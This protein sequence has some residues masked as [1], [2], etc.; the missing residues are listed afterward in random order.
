M[1]AAPPVPASQEANYDHISGD[2]PYLKRSYG[3]L[4]IKDMTQLYDDWAQTYD[5]DVI[6]GEEYKAPPLVAETILQNLGSSTI[7]PSVQILDVGCGTGLVGISLAKLGAQQVDGI[8]LSPGMLAIARKAGVY[9]KL[10][11]ADITK[12]IAFADE[13]YDVVSCVGTFT[14]GHVGPSALNEL[15]R[16]A[17]RKGLIVATVLDEIYEKLGYKA[18]VEKL[19]ADGKVEVI[20]TETMLYRTK[21]KA[22]A[23]NV[24][25]RRK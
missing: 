22:V 4:D 8:D 23:R 14:A 7:D 18:E 19:A 20:G 1:A 9:R 12:P 16:V 5:R 24:I 17:K 11:P 15:V 3:K 2:N 10:E 25:L 13:T 6:E 21:H